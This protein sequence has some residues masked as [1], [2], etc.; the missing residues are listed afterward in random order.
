MD[1]DNATLHYAMVIL[2]GKIHILKIDLQ[3]YSLYHG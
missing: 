3:F 2:G 1:G